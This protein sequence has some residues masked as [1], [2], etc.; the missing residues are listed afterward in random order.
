LLGL[1]IA[2]SALGAAAQTYPSKAVT[3]IV[4][5][6]P[7]GRTDLTARLTAQ[8][9]SEAISQPVVVVNQSGASGVAGAKKVASAAADG[10]TLGMFSSGVVATQ[11]TVPTPSD[12]GEYAPVALVNADSAAVAVNVSAPYRNLSE[13]VAYARSNP[14]K[15][16]LGTAPGT[17]AHLMSALFAKA[18]GIQ[19][20]LVPYGGG[21]GRS[22]ALAGNHIDVDVDVPAIYKGLLDA[23]RI[24]LLG[25]GAE[26]R[27]TLYRDLATLREQ[28]IDCVIGTWNAVFAPKSTPREI[29]AVL[30]RALATVARN[31]RFIEAMNAAFLEVRYL[32]RSD[33]EV[34]LKKEDST[35]RDLVKE[36]KIE[37][38]K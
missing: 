32:N 16:R 20:L 31:P 36:L 35:I 5:W 17:S 28:G 24:R 13:F 19:F 37:P 6:P 30:D 25:L 9:L 8:Y 14:G 3:L 12:L 15:V 7:G 1:A 4:P 27:S 33:F 11:Y 22:A 26:T 2:A 10:Y 38:P 21:G 23:G 29:T 34:F 18:A